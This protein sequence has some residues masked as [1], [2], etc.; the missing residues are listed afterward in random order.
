MERQVKL[1]AVDHR[2]V[3]R[4]KSSGSTKSTDYA[5]PVPEGQAHLP[6]TAIRPFPFRAIW[7]SAAPCSDISTFVTQP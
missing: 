6:R 2:P 4:E 3:I 7:N 1:R 5:K